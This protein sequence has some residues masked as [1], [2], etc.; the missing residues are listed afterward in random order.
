MPSIQ[1]SLAYLKNLHH[2][3]VWSLTTQQLMTLS[4]RADEGTNNEDSPIE[5]ME[6]LCVS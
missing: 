1:L 2:G 5:L 3:S 6:I 4:I